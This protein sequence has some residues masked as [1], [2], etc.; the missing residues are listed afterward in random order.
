MKKIIIALAAFASIAACNKAEVIET[1]EGEAISFSNPFVDNSTKAEKAEDPSFNGVTKFEEFQVWGTAN[2]VAIFNGEDV[3]GTVAE[4][5]VWKCAKKQYWVKDVAYK[6]AA[7]ANGS[8]EELNNGLPKKISYVADGVSDLVYAENLGL[9]D[10]GIIGQAADSNEP[11][12]FTFAHLLAKVKFTVETNTDIDGY[13][14]EVTDIKIDNAYASGTYTVDSKEWETTSGEGQDFSTITVD[15]D[16]KVQECAQ[17]KLLIPMNGVTVSYKIALKYGSE[18]IWQEDKT[19]DNAVTISNQEL[20]AANS[21]N[22]K[23]TANVG[24]EITFSV[25]ENPTW[26]YNSSPSQLFL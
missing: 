18:T 8:V 14:Y 16:N 15:Q 5:S 24:E 9:E 19:G 17:E 11:V 25:E 6:F 10:K 21:Y 7:V 23:I 26:D 13:S 2:G 22:F 12:E 3:E 4:N 20:E 1:P